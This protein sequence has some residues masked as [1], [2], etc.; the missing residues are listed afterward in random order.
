MVWLARSRGC[1][2]LPS[3]KRRAAATAIGAALLVGVAASTTRGA[4]PAS[5]SQSRVIDRTLL[6][7]PAEEGAPDTIRIMKLWA[8]PRSHSFPPNLT[9]SDR[10]VG[11]SQ[12]L[13]VMSTGPG[14][15]QFSGS[16]SLTRTPRCSMSRLRVALSSRGLEGG[17]TRGFDEHVCNVP[18]TVLVRIRAVFRRPAALSSDRLRPSL[19]F[20]RGTIETGYLAITTVRG[21]KPIAFASVTHATGKA[22]LFLE[23]RRCYAG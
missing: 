7:R 23:S 14:G 15:G 19:L 6:C 4:V 12:V 17:T 1:V 3:M 20:A 22:R 21:R 2:D 16:L 5:A 18:A 11:D 13:I 9:A 8:Y 10:G